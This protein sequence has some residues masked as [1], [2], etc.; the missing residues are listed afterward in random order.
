MISITDL[1]YSFFAINGIGRYTNNGRRFQISSK[2]IFFIT[3]KAPQAGELT[4]E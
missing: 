2:N 3:A 4:A 1:F